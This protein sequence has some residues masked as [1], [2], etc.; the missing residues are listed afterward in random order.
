MLSFFRTFESPI[1]QLSDYRCRSPRHAPHAEEEAGGNTIVLLRR[2]VFEKHF[3]RQRVMADAN[4][5]VFFTKGSVYKV[6]HPACGGDRGTVVAFSAAAL[7]DLVGHHDPTVAARPD[8]PFSLDSGPSDSAVFF[9]HREVLSLLSGN[10]CQADR[11]EV[12]NSALALGHAVLHAAFALRPA[13]AFARRAETART[14]RALTEETK[15][16]LAARLGESLSLE[17]IANAVNSTPFHLSRVFRAWSGVPIHRYLLS[18]RLRTA[19]ELV[20]AGAEDLSALGLQLGFSSHS[21]LTD[22]FRREFG[23]APSKLRR[24]DTRHALAAARQKG[25]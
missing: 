15:A 5:A 19:L 4:H 8:Q 2:G 21:H 16:Y 10:T 18:L 1:V 25:R 6:G 20:T 9:H 7:A 24:A 23:V 22:A 11:L 12:E 3:G 17:G 13:R 14:H